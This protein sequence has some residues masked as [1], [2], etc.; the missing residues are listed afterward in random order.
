MCLL[1]IIFEESSRGWG[2]EEVGVPTNHQEN[3]F[4]KCER[5][6]LTINEREKGDGPLRIKVRMK[7]L[8]AVMLLEK[9]KELKIKLSMVKFCKKCCVARSMIFEVCK[10]LK[11]YHKEDWMENN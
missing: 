10:K 3:I 8:C 6:I 7:S 11:E 2:L 5:Y 4:V 9:M 1:W